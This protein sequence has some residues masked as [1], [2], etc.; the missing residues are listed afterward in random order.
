MIHSSSFN[1]KRYSLIIKFEKCLLSPCLISRR[2]SLPSFANCLAS[3]WLSHCLIGSF[4]SHQSLTLWHLSSSL[5]W[6]S[7]NVSSFN[8]S[9]VSIRQS[10]IVVASSF[11]VH[12]PLSIDSRIHTTV[13]Q[14]KNIWIRFD[15]VGLLPRKRLIGLKNW[16]T[17]NFELAQEKTLIQPNLIHVHPYSL[18]PIFQY[19]T[20]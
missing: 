3:S 2:S 16:P 7:S 18:Q 19:K 11:T 17:Q 10:T 8:R 4:L 12:S 20:S 14:P 6:L 9:L 1:L 5:L 13:T 15:W